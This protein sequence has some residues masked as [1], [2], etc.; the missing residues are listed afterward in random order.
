MFVIIQENYCTS[1]DF[2]EIGSFDAFL[3]K[4][5]ESDRKKCGTA[6]RNEILSV[7]INDYIEVRKFITTAKYCDHIFMIYVLYTTCARMFY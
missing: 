1:T 3:H 7:K 2:D 5:K 6:L 4:I